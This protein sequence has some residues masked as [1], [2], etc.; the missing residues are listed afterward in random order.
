M[1]IVSIKE[2]LKAAEEA[3]LDLV[4]M[5]SN[6]NPVVCKIMDFGKFKYEKG[7]KEKEAK[8]NQKTVVV[9]E[10]KLKPRIDTH[11]LE[12]KSNRIEKFLTKGNKVKVSLMLFGRE[13]MHAEIGIKLLED[14][15]KRFEDMATVEKKIGAKENQ[16]FLILTPKK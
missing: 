14:L 7:K 10:I 11:D 5:A 16:K 3:G 1:G 8:K 6:A 2:A 4:E 9:K 13:R 12:V 15:A